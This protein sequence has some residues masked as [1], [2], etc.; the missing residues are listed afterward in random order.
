M[1]CLLIGAFIKRNFLL[2]A[3]LLG[4][5]EKNHYFCTRYF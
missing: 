3:Y 5:A 1:S 2:M 4:T